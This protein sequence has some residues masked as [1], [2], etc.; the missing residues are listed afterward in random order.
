MAARSGMTT[1][2]TDLRGMADVGTA[3]FSAGGVTWF[4]DDQLEDVLDRHAHHYT[5]HRLE[6]LPENIGGT[7]VYYRYGLPTPNLEGTASGTA[8]WRLEN[9]AGSA[10]SAAA[11]SID[12]NLQIITMAANQAGSALYLTARGYGLNAAAAVVWER[13]ADYYAARYDVQTDNHK[14]S[15]SQLIKHA[16]GRAKYYRNQALSERVTLVGG[17]ARIQRVD[18]N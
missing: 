6:A 18:T 13:K 8:V 14:L 3:E 5:R 4:T 10:F 2:I 17:M 15:R 1:L 16:E 11:F 12:H 9:S 7:T